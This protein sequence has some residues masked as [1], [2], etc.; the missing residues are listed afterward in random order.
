MKMTGAEIL[1]KSLEAEGVKDMFGYPGGVVLP[2]YD[3]LYDSKINHILVRHEQCAAHAADGYARSTGKVG[4]CMATSGPGST[5]L[6]TGIATAN[7]DSVP[8]VCFTGQV[9]TTSIGTDAFQEA[10]ITGITLPIVKHN[11]LAKDVKD[12]ANIIH[13]AFYVASTGRPGPVLI[14]V[15]VDVSKS[16]TTYKK[17]VQLNLP[18]YKPT[19]KGNIKQVKEAVKLIFESKKPLIYAGGGVK[20]SGASSELRKFVRKVKAPITATL[21]GKGV[22]PDTH[23]LSLG[24]PG[25]HGARYTNYAL[26]ETDLIVAIGV[27]FDDRVTGKLDTFAPHARI[28]HIDVD[29]AE[30][31]KNVP[32]NIPIV[33]DAKNILKSLNDEIDK[34]KKRNKPK[35]CKDWLRQI[36]QWKKK[37]PLKYEEAGGKGV[38]PETVV[39]VLYDLTKDKSPIVTTEVGQNQMW[40]AQYFK[41]NNPRHFLSSGGLGTMGYGLPAAMGAQVGNPRT[42]VIDIAGDGS[43]QM[44][45]QELATIVANKLPI[46]VV[47][48]NNGYLGMVRQWQELFYQERYSHSDLAVGTPDFVKLA[49]AYGAKG[50]RI[51]KKSEIRAKL[52]E[53]TSH[54]GPVVIDVLVE[55]MQ[56]VFP[57]VAPGA[58][59]NEMIGG[60]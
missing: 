27:R 24:M 55:R 4:V 39:E 45:S 12:L 3:V 8:I 46:K 36:D 18:G 7:M 9:P 52:K 16:T 35:E 30:I 38:N 19:L 37:Y 28:I 53:A 2:I 60:E 42:L 33:G 17:P 41:I 29:P 43:V 31:S 20:W 25:M 13:E 57:M 22:F 59:I 5:N 54:K 44:V 10:D 6:V 49:E 40:A 1:V 50:L 15:P 48:L 56:K 11:Y 23:K 51:I 47:I 21:M 34:Y 32:V 14:D 26:M 58:P